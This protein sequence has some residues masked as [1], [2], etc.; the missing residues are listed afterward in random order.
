MCMKKK[1]QFLLQPKPRL[2]AGFLAATHCASLP[3][4]SCPIIYS[5]RATNHSIRTFYPNPQQHL[6]MSHENQ[7]KQNN[8]HTPGQ[9]GTSRIDVPL[10]Q[11]MQHAVHLAYEA[12]KMAMSFCI[13]R[14]KPSTEA[15]TIQQDKLAVVEQIKG[16]QLKVETKVCFISTSLEQLFIQ[17]RIFL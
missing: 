13:S 5:P 2:V 3:F 16:N 15:S 12:G 11:V 6:K 7:S 1:I 4:P 9:N 17:N 10:A 14:P 8:N